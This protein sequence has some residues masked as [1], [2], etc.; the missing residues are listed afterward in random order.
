MTLSLLIWRVI[1]YSTSN[2]QYSAVHGGVAVNLTKNMDKITG[3]S[4]I[5]IAIINTDQS[6]YS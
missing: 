2:G 3:Q 5:G 1:Q 4:L 6:R